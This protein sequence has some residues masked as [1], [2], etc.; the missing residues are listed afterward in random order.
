[1]RVLVTPDY[2]S[3]SQTAA[4]LVIKAIRAKP[5]L[6]I[7][8]PTGNTPLGFYE[9][10]MKKHRAGSVDFSQ[11]TTFNLDEFLHLPQDHPQ[12]YHTYMRQHLFD[13]VNVPPQNI[14]IPNGSP[15]VDANAESE[16]YEEAIRKGGGIDLLVVGIGSNGH[17]AFNEPGA[18]FNS[19]TRAVDLAPETIAN[20]QQQFGGEPA[21][22]QAITM[23]I[24]TMLDA[25]RIVLLAAGAAKAAVVERALRGPAS[26]STPAS[27]LQLHK[28]VLAILDEAA[29]G[30]RK[31]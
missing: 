27:A 9:E 26:E 24:G 11:V 22:R 2:E 29:S 4:D 1:M 16:R 3:L 12:S 10:L 15:G 31:S 5:T 13:H 19:R 23:G 25:R 17:I 7:G 20:A 8:L 14:H 21:P 6:R 30:P 28:E 18:A